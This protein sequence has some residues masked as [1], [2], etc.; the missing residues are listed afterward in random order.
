ML[1]RTAKSICDLGI[2]LD[3]QLTM[4]THLKEVRCCYHKLCRIRQIRRLV[5]QDVTQQLVSAYILS[6]LDYCNALLSHLPGST[7]Q[8]LQ[9][10][11]NAAAWV[12]MNLS[13]CDHVK[14]ALKQLHWLPVEQRITYKPC[15]FMHHIHIGQAPQCLSDCVSTV[16]AASGRYQLRST[17]LAVYVLPKTRS[18]FGKRGFFSGPAAWLS[19]RHSG[20]YLHQCIQE[21]TKVRLHQSQLT[22]TTS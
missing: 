3:S 20:H 8:P 10:V 9:R 16:S 11:M 12:V 14:P 22:L 5:W 21:T 2:H 15:L 13:L 1:I 17:G 6:R 18:R 4:K 7:I 19:F